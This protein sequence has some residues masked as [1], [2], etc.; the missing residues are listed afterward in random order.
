MESK[1][2][3]LVQLK[4]YVASRIAD[5]WYDVGIQLLFTSEEL[6]QIEQNC[7][8]IPVEM[9]CKKMLYLWIQRN[10]FITANEL[11]DAIRNSGNV[12]YASQLQKGQEE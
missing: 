1:P 9:C 7:C 12:Y 3:S 5:R 8:P 4:R 10:K 11:I 6:D 2:E